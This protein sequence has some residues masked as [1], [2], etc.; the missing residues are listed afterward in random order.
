M[1]EI[2]PN[3]ARERR[4]ADEIVVD[5]YT[6]GERTMGWYYYLEGKMSF[7]VMARCLA[8]RS[9]SPLK[10]GEEAQVVPWRT[11]TTVWRGCSYS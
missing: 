3:R 8:A 10:K 6:S 5:A 7:P 2:H 9:V 1:N 11:R 4:I